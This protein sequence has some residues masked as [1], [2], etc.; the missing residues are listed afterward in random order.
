MEYYCKKNLSKLNAISILNIVVLVKFM[1]GVGRFG[2]VVLGAHA[3][4]I[5]SIIVYSIIGI[6]LLVQYKFENLKVYSKSIYKVYSKSIY[7]AIFYSA[8]LAISLTVTSDYTTTVKN[9]FE[10]LVTIL[11]ANYLANKLSLNKLLDYTINAQFIILILI[12]IMMLAFKGVAYDNSGALVGIFSTK[13]NMAGE[14]TFSILITL[15]KIRWLMTN[16]QKGILKYVLFIIIQFYLII[17]C[18]A[19]G[20]IVC[21]ILP[22]VIMIV[23]D[24]R[25][26]TV[27][28]GKMYLL[29]NV[30]FGSIVVYCLSIFNGVLQTFGRNITLTGRLPIWNII[31]SEMM[32]GNKWFGYGY[33]T[34]WDVNNDIFLKIC[35][36]YNLVLGGIPVGSHNGLIEL[37]MSIGIVGVVVFLL[38]IYKIC[39][40][41]RNM[42][43]SPERFFICIYIL[44]FAV[45]S[46]TERSLGAFNYQTLVLFVVLWLVIK[47]SE[48]SSIRYFKTMKQYE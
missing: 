42:S 31:T 29:I 13:N 11:Y 9:C 36:Q 1:G 17:L 32:L 37:W 8:L 16:K 21:M 24:H 41:T 28:L 44:Y 45:Y 34:A 20:A 15:S 3:E 6:E 10:L 27:S 30:V 48:T 18:K 12:F 19:V 40:H 26:S 33:G 35:R 2:D 4:T 25:N 43:S 23:I 39:A 47:I 22:F 46:L 7:I 38:M 5:F 14:L